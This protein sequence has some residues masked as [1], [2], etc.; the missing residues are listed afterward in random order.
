MW[1]LPGS[2]RSAM[3]ANP[4]KWC[5]VSRPQGHTIEG[6]GLQHPVYGPIKKRTAANRWG[7]PVPTSMAGQVVA[8]DDVGAAPGRP[9]GTACRAASA[10]RKHLHRST[11]S[12]LP[13]RFPENGGGRA[14]GTRL[15]TNVF[16]DALFPPS[17]PAQVGATYCAKKR[18]AKPPMPLMSSNRSREPPR[19]KIERRHRSWMCRWV[20]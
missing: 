4:R 19:W 1:W 18:D 6:C 8:A 16:S 3:S 12:W 10:S 14:P 15:Q 2:V 9:T 5:D 13:A 7:C 17:L 11:A 20:I